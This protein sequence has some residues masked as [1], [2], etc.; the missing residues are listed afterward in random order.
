MYLMNNV[1]FT[2]TGGGVNTLK[3][4]QPPQILP[5]PPGS[6]STQTKVTVPQPASSPQITLPTQQQQTILFNQVNKHSFFFSGFT[7]HHTNVLMTE[8][9]T[10]QI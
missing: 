2:V 9:S 1:T 4:K 10:I 6:V 5:K 8:D 3:T 7:Q